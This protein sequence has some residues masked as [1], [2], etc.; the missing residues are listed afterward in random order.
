MKD[1]MNNFI[2]VCPYIELTICFP[3]IAINIYSAVRF[4]NI[5]SFNNNF[6]IIMI[7][8]NF[9]V[10]G[11]SILHPIISLT[12]AYYI[13]YQTGNF[14]ETTAFYFIAYIHQTCTFIFDIKYFILGFERWFAFRSRATY[15]HSKDNTSVKVFICMIFSSLLKT[16]NE[17][18]F[19][20]KTLTESYQIKETI[21]ILS[22]I[23]PIIK[24]YL[25]V[26]VA[27]T[28]CVSINMYGLM[29]GLWQKY[30]NYYQGLTNLEY[31]F[32]NMYNFYS[33]SYAIWYLRPLRRVFLTDLRSL[34]RTSIDID[35]RVNP[36]VEKY[37]DEAKIYFDQLQSQW[38]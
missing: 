27:C 24:A 29:F 37:D 25:T 18:K 32:I 33:S 22:V 12:P 9:I 34:F 4:A 7:V 16:A 35:N 23:Q 3:C 15:E 28:I 19:S 31:I 17:H 38:S 6:R 1:V 21:N 36:S 10:A 26:V 20:G 2:A 5:H 13:S 8:T 30:S 11:I 14:I